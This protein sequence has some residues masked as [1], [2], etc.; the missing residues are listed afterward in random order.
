M[1]STHISTPTDALT[2]KNTGTQATEAPFD[3]KDRREY[4]HAR[5]RALKPSDR[6]IKRIFKLPKRP[7]GNIGRGAKK[8][9]INTGH[10]A[11]R[12]APNPR[13]DAW[14]K[15]V[16][17]VLYDDDVVD[18]V[19]GQLQFERAEDRAVAPRDP[20]LRTITRL[21]LNCDLSWSWRKQ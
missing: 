4:E 5:Q 10:N 21:Y 8:H 3:V 11:I 19:R 16:D 2:A 6:V 14:I 15:K 13:W 18:D 17:L 1:S 20:V 9:L 12:Y 7:E